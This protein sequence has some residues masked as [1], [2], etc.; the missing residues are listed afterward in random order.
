MK[1]PFYMLK[2]TNKK[3]KQRLLPPTLPVPMV[4]EN[5]LL[6]STP[7]AY[8]YPTL[9]PR[10]SKAESDMSRNFGLQNIFDLLPL[11]LVHSK[12]FFHCLLKFFPV[13]NFSDFF[14]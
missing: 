10:H 5:Q 7:S 2:I 12:F 9:P 14:N 1:N 8:P 13:F 4:T 3:E 11:S 6:L